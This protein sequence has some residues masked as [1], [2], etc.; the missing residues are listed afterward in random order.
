MQNR[1]HKKREDYLSTRNEKE[2]KEQ[3][4]KQLCLYFILVKIV[5][6]GSSSTPA[7]M[8]SMPT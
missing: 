3:R 6:G 7:T 2:T 8:V 4:S 1:A 5:S